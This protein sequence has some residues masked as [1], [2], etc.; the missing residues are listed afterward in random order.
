LAAIAISGALSGPEST[1]ENPAKYGWF[2]KLARTGIRPSAGF[3][4]GVERLTRYIAGL[5]NIWQ[6]SAFPKLPGVVS[7]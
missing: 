2:L 6:A 1:G 3:G 4:L 5:E 7:P